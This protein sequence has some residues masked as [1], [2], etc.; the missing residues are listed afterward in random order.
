M[1]RDMMQ[2]LQKLQKEMEETQ[3][4]LQMTEF[5]G[6]ASGVKVIMLGTH[7][8]VDI[9]IDEM[10]LEDADMLQDALS[11][12]I[13]DAVENVKKTTEKEMGKF[14]TGLGMGF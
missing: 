5:E 7:Q 1:N 6:I 9:Q 14:T 11:I 2:K 8:V 12:A 3:E 13:N 10:L 4:R